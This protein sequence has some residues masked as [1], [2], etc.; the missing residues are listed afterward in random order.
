MGKKP[1][2]AKAKAKS[3]AKALAKASSSGS[4]A[5]SKQSVELAGN[6]KRVSPGYKSSFIY[7]LHVLLY[8]LMKKQR[9]PNNEMDK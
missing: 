1:P 7:L 9:N 6:I 8:L 4:V 2:A 5:T 3:K